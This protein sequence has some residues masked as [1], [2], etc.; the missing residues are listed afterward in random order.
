MHKS[1]VVDTYAFL[2]YSLTSFQ[3]QLVLAAPQQ[4]LPEAADVD[5]SG[6]MRFSCN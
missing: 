1:A 5:A 4:H 3:M 6:K 2:L